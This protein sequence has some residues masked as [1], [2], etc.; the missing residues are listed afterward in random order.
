MIR[1]AVTGQS[2]HYRVQLEVAVSV[3]VKSYCGHLVVIIAIIIIFFFFFL[4]FL[5]EKKK[6][7][8]PHSE[9]YSY[10]TLRL[11]WFQQHQAQPVAGPFVAGKLAQ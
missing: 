3:Q 4:F 7:K 9:W 8:L 1:P 5:F 10:P 11:R 2:I 6:E